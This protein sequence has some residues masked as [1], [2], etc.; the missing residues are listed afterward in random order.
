[1]PSTPMPQF[2][3]ITDV[4]STDCNHTAA[5]NCTLINKGKMLLNKLLHTCKNIMII[6]VTDN[7]LTLVGL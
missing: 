3:L 7:V 1:M 4:F 2:A 5:V 6:Q